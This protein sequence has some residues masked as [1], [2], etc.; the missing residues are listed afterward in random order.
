MGVWCIFKPAEANLM[1]HV[2]F[3]F[4]YFPSCLTPSCFSAAYKQHLV[5]LLGRWLWHI[6]LQPLYWRGRYPRIKTISCCWKA[7]ISGSVSLRVSGW[8]SARVQLCPV[9]VLCSHCSVFHLNCDVSQRWTPGWKWVWSSRLNWCS[10]W[11]QLSRQ[12]PFCRLSLQLHPQ[13]S[14]GIF[15]RQDLKN[16]DRTVWS[17]L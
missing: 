14:R 10:K 8:A 7:W 16:D 3:V 6:W 12:I 4:S 15:T 11:W 13:V 2:V 9:L 1:V 5:R 17:W